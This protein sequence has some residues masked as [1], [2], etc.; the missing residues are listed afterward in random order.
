MRI[1]SV[2]LPAIINDD[3]TGL[4]DEEILAVSK[5]VDS[6]SACI[7]STDTIEAFFSVCEL[8]GLRGCCVELTIKRP[9]FKTRYINCRRGA[10]VETV[11]E[12][13][14]N[15]FTDRGFVAELKRLVR[16]YQL[17]DPTAYYYISNRS[18]A[19]WRAK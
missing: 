4:T 19:S 10:T 17:S 5:L 11:G 7:M 9:Q 2:F 1:L 13:D 14:N 3:Y 8:T 6:Y 16:E 12:L 15:R 18:T